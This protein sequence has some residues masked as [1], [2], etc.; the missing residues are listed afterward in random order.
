MY[1]PFLM[2][3]TVLAGLATFPAFAQEDETEEVI[4]IEATRS[5]TPAEA[6]PNA[7][8]LI[9]RE[10]IE[11]QLAI[12]T[13]IL[14]A[15][16]QVAP[17]TAPTRQ[18]LSTAGESFRG[19]NP[20][21]L[22][23]GVPQS[24]PLRN[25]SRDG[26][27]LDP[28]VIERVEILYGA[29]AIQGIGATGGLINYVT[30]APA[31][32]DGWQL[33][34]EAGI[35]VADGFEDDGTS[36]RG[37]ATALGRF[38]NFDIVASAAVEDRGIFYDAKDRRIGVDTTQGDIQDSQSLNL[39]GKVGWEPDDKTRLQL[40]INTFDLEGNGDYVEVVGDRDAGI[41]TISIKGTYQGI[42]ATNDVMTVSFD[43]SREDV[44]G[45]TLSGQIFMQDFE[46]VYGGGVFGTFQDPDI[47]PSGMLFDQSA[48]NSEKQGFKTTWVNDSLP[49]DGMTVTA[50]FDYL[51]DKT[52]QELVQ[53]GRLWVPE[54]EF[55]SNSPFIQL[56]QTLL[57]ER[58]L[59]SGG[60]RYIDAEFNTD[61][62]TTLYS[63]GPVTVD[64][65]TPSFKDTL[66]NIGA[67]FEVID[68]LTF[69]GS[70]AEG[71]TM[72]DVGRVLRGVTDPDA[73]VDTL[74]NLQPIVADNM[75]VGVKFEQGRFSGDAAWFQSESDFGQ[76]LVANADGIFAVNREQTE[77]EGIELRGRFQVTE[78]VAVGANYANLD[79]RFDSDDDGSVDS[80]LTG[81][82]ISPNRLNTY[83][84]ATLTPA[85]SLRGQ[86]STY[87]DRDFDDAGDATDFDGYTLVDL[88]ASYRV[89]D[90]GKL[91]LGIQNLLNEDYIHYYSQSGTTTEA[92]YFAGRGR[93]MTLRW[94]GA[95]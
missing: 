12:S 30:L 9:E 20:L 73:D 44:F 60:L 45:G 85:L 2:A 48:N 82:N 70:Y 58:L 22:I 89:G 15:I 1:K 94:T 63:Y 17:S 13:S 50:G 14:D 24:N 76:R 64:G 80:D 56:S 86:S 43:A 36:Y 16:G 83:V 27:T 26:F 75:E 69:Y 10:D 52:F 79:G 19:R 47:D 18:K 55:T 29:N 23:D 49:V 92:R 88:L 28:A 46:A 11:D 38:G 77:I 53:T 59:V 61:T 84:E 72:P 39:F 71:F 57:D 40:M 93:A 35:T 42:P 91:D 62:F 32:E 65:G 95:F 78:A 37:A 90:K 7:V 87:F 6:L 81:A 66:G 74:L 67:S 4:V 34:Y 54:T 8:S 68:G 33:R 21:Y 25:G 51:K 3:G 31:K 5:S 41:P